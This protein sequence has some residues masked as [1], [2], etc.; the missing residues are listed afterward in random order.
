M[1]K[2]I[3]IVTVLVLLTA[4]IIAGYMMEEYN[5]SNS[6]EPEIGIA[7]PAAVY[8]KELGYEYKII[9]DSEG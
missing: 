1:K 8:C 6:N 9:S 3:L 5:T 7:D 4:A 2:K